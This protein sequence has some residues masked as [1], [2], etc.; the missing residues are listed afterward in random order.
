MGIFAEIVKTFSIFFADSKWMFKHCAQSA[1]NFTFSYR[2]ILFINEE[3]LYSR[4]LCKMK[5]NV[6]Q[7]TKGLPDG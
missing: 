4:S 6:T 2:H 7:T 1:H 5:G 3:M